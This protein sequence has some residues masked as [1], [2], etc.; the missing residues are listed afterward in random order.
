MS[1]TMADV[2]KR[3]GASIATVGRVIHN[4][5]YVSKEVRARVESAIA[6]LEYVPNQNART[7]KRSRSGII[8]NL[9]QQSING[10][11]YRINDSIMNA[12]HK[13]GYECLTME[14][15]HGLNDEDRIIQNFIGMQI[16]G[17][18]IISN[19]SVSPE[20]FAQLR[21]AKI[22]VVAVERGYCEEKTDSLL[23]KD[24]EA[25]KDAV[26]RI[27]AQGHKRIGIIAIP[28]ELEV[29]R[30]RLE[31]SKEALKEAGLPIDGELIRIVSGYDASEGRK[32]AE[33]LFSLPD[34]PTAIFATA[35]TLA[36]GVLQAAYERNLRVPEDISLVGYDDV[37]SQ[38]LSPMINS[39]GLLL[40]N[41]G[42]DVMELL[43]ERQSDFERPVQR[44]MIDTAYID[45]GTVIR[46]DN[47]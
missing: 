1:A 33:E 7:L 24:F 29:E 5:G 27:I 34:P 11:Y 30:Q 36:A 17:L 18:V 15:R 25:C 21:R 28:P 16:E 43:L 35:D 13:R 4:N 31:G 44:R 20:M 45:R 10:L 23:V 3:A 12:A 42:D 47:K 8:G 46:R 26:S 2:A 39:V 22:P 6:E 40:E 19:S 14:A 37:L 9:V 32:A 41:I 38:T